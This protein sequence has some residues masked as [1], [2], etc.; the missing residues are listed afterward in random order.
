[1]AAIV[2][3]LDNYSPTQFGENGHV[4]YGWSNNIQEKILQFSFQVT[5]TNEDGVARLSVV[6]HDLLSN[7]KH[8]AE[9]GTLPEKEV[10]R[11]HLSILY[12]MIGQTRDIVDGKGE[13]SLSYMMVHTWNKFYPSLAQ[14]ALRCFVT[15]DNK[16]VHQYGSWKDLKYFCEY[17]KS[18][19]DS[20]TSPLIKFAVSLINEQIKRDYASLVSNS[21]D[22]SLAAKWAPREKSSFGWLY[23]ALAVDYF[24]NFLTTLK[25]NKRPSNEIFTE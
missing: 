25:H 8:K 1:M 3:A 13:C 16:E 17:C 12:R 24:S 19:G 6:L 23:D 2:N 9:T 5:R 15:L 14:F 21:N 11:G 4:E 18:Q 22:I 7:L 20:I 10:A